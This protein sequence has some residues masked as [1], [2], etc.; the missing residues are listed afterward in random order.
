MFFLDYV[1]DGDR[2]FFK[3]IKIV[4]SNKKDL[5]LIETN[6]SDSNTDE[7]TQV[8]TVFEY[9]N[10]VIIYDEESAITLIISKSNT[11]N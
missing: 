2:I 10:G 7:N 4:D 8:K 11:K 5:V 6:D 1:V 9:L 3:V